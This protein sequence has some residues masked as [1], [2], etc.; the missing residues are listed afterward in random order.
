MGNAVGIVSQLGLSDLWK[1][2]FNSMEWRSNCCQEFIV[3][4]CIT[5]EVEIESSDGECGDCA[6]CLGCDTSES[7]ETDLFSRGDV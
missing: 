6:T 7:N 3:C 4:E 1:Y 2:V 5:K